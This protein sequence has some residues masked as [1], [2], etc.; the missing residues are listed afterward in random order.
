MTASADP[1]GSGHQP[2]LHLQVPAVFSESYALL[3]P[4][5]I[6]PAETMSGFAM[7]HML[8]NRHPEPTDAEIHVLITAA[9]HALQGRT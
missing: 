2:E 5:L 6:D 4:L 1:P 3:A 9:T 8:D 7:A